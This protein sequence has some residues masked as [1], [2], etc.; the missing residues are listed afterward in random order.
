MARE[1]WTELLNRI[2]RHL[3]EEAAF[4]SDQKRRSDLFNYELFRDILAQNLIDF[5]GTADVSAAGI[6]RVMARLGA[7]FE[8]VAV[9]ASE[10][11]ASQRSEQL[12]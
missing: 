6:Q 7:E 1:S 2:E 4:E 9:D 8:R 11:A 10:Q 5:L 3:A 12:T